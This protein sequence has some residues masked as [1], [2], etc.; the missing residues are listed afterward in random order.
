MRHPVSVCVP[1]NYRVTL[2]VRAES[3]GV[4]QY[5]W[6]TNDEKMVCEVSDAPAFPKTLVFYNVLIKSNVYKNVFVYSSV[7]HVYSGALLWALE[8]ITETSYTDRG[9]LS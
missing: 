4:L 9:L 6:F 8:L 1:A 5:Q 2:S 3:T 7:V